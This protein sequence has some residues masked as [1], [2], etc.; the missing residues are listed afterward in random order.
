MS[1]LPYVTGH[2]DQ[3]WYNEAGFRWEHQEAE[4]LWG[5]ILEADYHKKYRAAK[6][7]GLWVNMREAIKT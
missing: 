7:R 2:T 3:P 5:A 1:L 4:G 6:G